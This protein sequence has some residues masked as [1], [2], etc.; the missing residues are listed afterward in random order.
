[1][2]LPVLAGLSGVQAG[3]TSGYA[4]AEGDRAIG[5]PLPPNT[6]IWYPTGQV[7]GPQQPGSDSGIAGIPEGFGPAYGADPRA[8]KTTRP[9]FLPVRRYPAGEGGGL[10]SST[11]GT[12]TWWR[13]G[14]QGFNDQLRIV[15]RHAYWDTG[16]QKTGL[17]KL[18]QG[19]INTYNDPLVNGPARNLRT[20]NRSLTYQRGSDNTANQDDL[21]R[22]YNRN[23]Q[24]MYVGEQGSGWSPVY[25]GTP[26]LYEPYGTRG[27]VPYPIASPVPYG[28]A[29][30]G[31]QKVFSGPPHG[32]HS[33]TYPDRSLTLS[34]YTAAPQMRPVRF[35][36][37]S[38]S[39]QAGQTYSQ[40]VLPQGASPQQPR[41]AR[42]AAV[43]G[44]SGRGW[45]GTGS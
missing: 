24:G 32:L 8:P 12:P 41:T 14:I 44:F 35:D 28:A 42:G 21:N 5:N 37:P 13:A 34:R 19:Q 9:V 40:T 3:R 38:N 10:D 26:G 29:G 1:M 30:D 23:P 45:K 31:P 22:P 15:D 18:P 27:G 7:P 11:C 2:R 16:N 25:G 43:A 20:V 36:R 4:P 17:A 39:P 6:G 33:L